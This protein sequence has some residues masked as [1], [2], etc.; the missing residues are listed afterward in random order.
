MKAGTCTKLVCSEILSSC[1]CCNGSALS[2]APSTGS[3]SRGREPDVDVVSNSLN[4]FIACVLHR[5]RCN[6]CLSDINRIIIEC[7]RVVEEANSSQKYN[8][9]K[10]HIIAQIRHVHWIG[11][12]TTRRIY[13]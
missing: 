13:L 1:N 8:I 4:L 10:S 12:A 5:Y 11:L 7:L 3:A 6:V 9:G 2:P